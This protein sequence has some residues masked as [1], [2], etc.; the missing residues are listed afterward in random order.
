MTASAAMPSILSH[1]L[2]EKPRGLKVRMP[3]IVARMW[4]L[5][6]YNNCGKS[7]ESGFVDG[8]FSESTV[9]YPSLKVN[10]HPELPSILSHF[11]ERNKMT[12]DA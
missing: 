1:M 11:D 2:S 10:K 5:H 8:V 3:S 7:F 12:S 6:P 4:G 9:S